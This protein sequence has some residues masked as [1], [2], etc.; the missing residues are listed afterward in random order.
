MRKFFA[1]TLAEVLITL[2]IIGIVAALTMPSLIANHR[3]KTYEAQ[4]KKTANTI[5]NG[6]KRILA[7][8]Q[9]DDLTNTR[10]Y[11]HIGHAMHEDTLNSYIG[12][13]FNIVRNGWTTDQRTYKTIKA[14]NSHYSQGCYLITTADGADICLV[15][16]GSYSQKINAYVDTNG[17]EKLPNTVGLDFFIMSFDENGAIY[18]HSASGSVDRCTGSHVAAPNECFFQV[19]HDNWEITYY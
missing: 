5:T 17:Y 6:L 12:N 13:Y 2:G 10:F 3:K 1:F 18:P 15:S 4:L 19:L 7:D 8:D 14:G 16:P 11:A 9:V